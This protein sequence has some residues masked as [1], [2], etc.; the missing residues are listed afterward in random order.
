MKT[1]ILTDNVHA[2]ALAV[3]LQAGYDDVDVYQSPIGQLP[4]VPRF[5]VK[6]RVADTVERY[7]L[8]FSLH[9][10]Q[11]FPD[12]LLDGVRCVNVHPGFNPCNRGWFPQV[13]SIIDGQKV[14]VTI[15]EMDDKLDHGPIIAQRE[16]AIEPW[17]TSGS[18][19]ARLMDIERELVLEHFD[20]IR[21]RSYTAIP[22]PGEGNLNL[23]K[24]FEQ[25]RQLDLN[26]HATF[27]HFLNRLRALTHDDFRNAWF[28][29]ASGRR[30]FVR[31]VLEPEAD[32]G[33]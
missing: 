32:P 7:D 30:V 6:E 25:L 27:G 21:D 22:P 5:D 29:D 4:D 23:K 3:Q 20:A 15:H 9:C 13:F 2:H 14:G 33:P 28:V 1:L 16:C 24:D 19:Y 10:K 8:V 17:D 26:E 12:A 18:V 31:V 11:K